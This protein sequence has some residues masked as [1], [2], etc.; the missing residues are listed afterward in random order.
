MCC[1]LGAQQIVM[2]PGAGLKVEPEQAFAQALFG[3]FLGAE[4][5]FDDRDPSA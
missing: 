2:K 3:F 5:V 4:F 1:C